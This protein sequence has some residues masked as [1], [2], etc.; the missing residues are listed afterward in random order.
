VVE[1]DTSRKMDWKSRADC[2]A[3]TV[4]R[5]KFGGFFLWVHVKEQVYTVPLRKVE[6]LLRR[7][8]AA[9]T[10]VDGNMLRR[11]KENTMRLIAVCLEMD[12][13]YF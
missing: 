2:A 1:R 10:A 7:L 6:G 5:C 3:F 4:A 11:V 9:V 8:Q 12:G 13:R